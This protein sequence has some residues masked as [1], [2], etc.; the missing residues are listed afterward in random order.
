M[1]KVKV[2]SFCVSMDGYGAA[3]DQSQSNPFGV[4]GMVLP[5]WVM[6]TRVFQTTVL[7]R[8]SGTTGIDNAFMERGTVNIGAT[9]MGRNMFSPLRGPWKDDSWKGWWGP[10]PPFHCDVFVLT[11]HPRPILE[12]EGGNRFIFV[13]DGIES[14]M[15]QAKAAAGAK[16]IRIGGGVA[17]VR[18]YL[19]AGLVDELHLAFAPLFLGHGENLL[20]GLDLPK[21]GFEVAERVQGEGALHVVLRKKG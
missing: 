9:I 12:M 3:L 15:K 7:G 19:Q 4:G 17:T 5:A 1:G 8:D 21:L 18:A 13:T 11:H 16:D 20:Q 14:A 2:A 10:N 6:P